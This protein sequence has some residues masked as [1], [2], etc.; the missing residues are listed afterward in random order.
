ML[1][2]RNRDTK[3]CFLVRLQALYRPKW[4]G[5][6]ARGV[7]G[8]FTIIASGRLWSTP[9]DSNGYNETAKTS[10]TAPLKKHG[11]RSSRLKLLC[12][13]PKGSALTAKKEN[14]GRVDLSRSTL[15]ARTQDDGK[16]PTQ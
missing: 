15:P 16:P 12:T 3:K 5:V 8:N 1:S 13:S 10:P 6:K 7:P 11:G 2:I 4:T 14:L 9:V